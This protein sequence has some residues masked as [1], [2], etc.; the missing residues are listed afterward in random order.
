MGKSEARSQLLQTADLVAPSSILIE[1]ERV[2]S[3][4]ALPR[5]SHTGSYLAYL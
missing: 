2:F 5:Q 4:E 1:V 3:F